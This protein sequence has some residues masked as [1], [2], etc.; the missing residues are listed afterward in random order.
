MTSIRV[1][2][3]IKLSATLITIVEVSIEY[4]EDCS[5]D[6]KAWELS[7][8][9]DC[10][11]RKVGV[12]HLI[13][14]VWLATREELDEMVERER[15]DWWIRGGDPYK[16]REQERAHPNRRKITHQNI[17]P[18]RIKIAHYNKDNPPKYTQHIGS[19]IKLVLNIS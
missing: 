5:G 1:Y 4:A 14:D 12:F 6:I 10:Y 3:V 9:K 8:F 2:Q 16:G 15:R 13:C 7:Y 11:F 19:H 17:Q 18:I